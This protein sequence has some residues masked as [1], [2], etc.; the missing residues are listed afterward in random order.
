MGYY[1][2]LLKKARCKK[3]GLAY[4]FQIIDKVPND[5]WDIKVDKV[6]TESKT[7]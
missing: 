6:I 1:D 4:D 5:E 7:I 2:T 3:I